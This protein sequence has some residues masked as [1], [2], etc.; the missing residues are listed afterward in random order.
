MQD[1]RHAK[2]STVYGYRYDPNLKGEGLFTCNSCTSQFYGGA[3]RHILSCPMKEEPCNKWCIYVF[4]PDEV[5][6]EVEVV[7]TL[8]DANVT[9]PL[10]VSV[11]WALYP[12][13][14][15]K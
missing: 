15:P 9:G 3:D 12:E 1:V 5:K 11:I 2:G 4:G 13:L 10:Q 8:R 6:E 14:V 7:R